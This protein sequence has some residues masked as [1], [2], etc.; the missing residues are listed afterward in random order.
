[1][2]TY[3]EDSVFTGRDQQSSQNFVDKDVVVERLIGTLKEVLPEPPLINQP[4]QSEFAETTLKRSKRKSKFTR[5]QDEMIVDL[6]SKGKSWVDIAQIAGV[7]SFLAAR[8][9]YQVLIGQQGVG[10]SIWGAG[11]SQ[12]LQS[13]VDDGEL[14][15]WRFISR[16]MYK[17]T[18][19]QFTDVQCR[20]LIRDIFLQDPE[21]FGVSEDALNEITEVKDEVYEPSQSEQQHESYESSQQQSQPHQETQQHEHSHHHQQQQQYNQD[22]NRSYDQNF[23]HNLGQGNPNYSQG[24]NTH[25]THLYEQNKNQNNNSGYN[26]Y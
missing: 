14:E 5:E 17:L 10:S 6:K 12:N 2:G 25:Q 26:N 22:Y 20:E 19:K 1:M 21:E 3:N 9:R 4:L 11:D 7:G 15:K 16:E 23:N 8:N 24:Q 13:L 18:G